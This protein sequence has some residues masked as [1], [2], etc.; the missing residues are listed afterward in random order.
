MSPSRF[1]VTLAALALGG[2]V[3]DAQTPL[4]RALAP[5]KK[6]QD[7]SFESGDQ[8]EKLRDGVISLSD[9]GKVAIRQKA[10]NIVYKVTEPEYHEAVRVKDDAIRPRDP[11]KTVD[12]LADEIQRTFISY[13]A[14]D[15]LNENQKDY[16]RELGAALFDAVLLVMTDKNPPPF[17]RL[18]AARLLVP[19]AETASPA[20]AR[21]LTKILSGGV[22]TDD[23]KAPA[24][25]PPDVLYYALRGCEAFLDKYQV[26][27]PGTKDLVPD[28]MAALLGLL[29]GYVEKGPPILNKVSVSA[30]DP[31]AAQATA[32]DAA[33]RFYRLQ[34]VRALAKVKLDEYPG[35]N[36]V[37]RPLFTLAR[38]AVRDP[39]IQPPPSV[40]EVGEATLG[41]MSVNAGLEVNVEVLAYVA[42]RGATDYFRTRAEAA[43]E[44]K[45]IDW[46]AAAQRFSVAAAAWA[47]A[48]EKNPAVRAGGKKAVE[49]AAAQLE[50]YLFAPLNNPAAA[51]GAGPNVNEVARWL[52]GV[53]AGLPD[54]LISDRQDKSKYK[55]NYPN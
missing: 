1:A 40:K 3:A 27:R 7:V 20:V 53:K 51:L 23:K 12:K 28:D 33:V 24:P 16:Q 26:L 36:V 37:L 5:Y 38:V 55:L 41:L 45:L 34:A 17:L 50:Q 13:T 8:L 47:A 42:A 49:A 2:S 18:N 9:K 6:S 48:T 15:K 14:W 4:E 25:P 54:A 35:K 22:F 52:G 32:R 44:M 11:N 43:P 10:Q 19:A 46:K 29:I 30:G 39:A 31:P 21:G